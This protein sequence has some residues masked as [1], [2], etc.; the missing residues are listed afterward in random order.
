MHTIN[1]KIL[2]LTRY[3]FYKTLFRPN[4]FFFIICFALFKIK[5]SKWLMCVCRTLTYFIFGWRRWLFQQLMMWC[6]RARVF[7]IQTFWWALRITYEIS[8]Q[9]L[10]LVQCER[11]W[12]KWNEWWMSECFWVRARV[13]CKKLDT[14]T[15]FNT[16]T[17]ILYADFTLLQNSTV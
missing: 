6:V 16:P 1:L 7:K 11:V 10:S 13:R 3:R 8:Y 17:P 12:M 2:Q 4:S 5:S 14:K 9:K 15:I